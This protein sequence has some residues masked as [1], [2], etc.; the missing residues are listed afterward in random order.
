MNK[1]KLM[2]IGF[3]LFNL[4]V[5]QESYGTGS[6]RDIQQCGDG[7]ILSCDNTN[8]TISC[9]CVSHSLKQEQ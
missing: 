9:K 4:L 8:E 7:T 6:D 2:T 5:L 1:L 3:V